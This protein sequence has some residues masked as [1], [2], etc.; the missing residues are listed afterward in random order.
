MFRRPPRSP[1]FP[2]PTLFRSAREHGPSLTGSRLLNGSTTRHRDFELALADFLGREDALV[3]TTGYQANIGLISALMG[4]DS[5]L[6]RKS[7][8]LNASHANISY[9]VF[10]L[11]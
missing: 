11:T 10:C 9:A 7:T 6:D 1:L 4:D 5:V 3:F 2:S 8:R